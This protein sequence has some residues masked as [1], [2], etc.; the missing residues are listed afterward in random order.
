MVNDQLVNLNN[1][2]Y[3]NSTSCFKQRQTGL[4]NKSVI[5]NIKDKL[6]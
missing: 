2:D 1:F 5:K 6:N 4:L 3:R